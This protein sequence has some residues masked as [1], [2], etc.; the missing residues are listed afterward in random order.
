MTSCGVAFAAVIG[1]IAMMSGGLVRG[2]QPILANYIPVIDHPLFIAGLATFFAGTVVFFINT[3]ATTRPGA[4][5]EATP[6][7][8]PADASTGLLA[9]GVAVILAHIYAVFAWRPTALSVGQ[10]YPFL[11]EQGRSGCK[12]FPATPGSRHPVRFLPRCFPGELR[13]WP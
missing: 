1:V 11:L 6:G 9:T 5:G 10:F 12:G 13:Q 4:A 8:L 3:L 7:G 2:A